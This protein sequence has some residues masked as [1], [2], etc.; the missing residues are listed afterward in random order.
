MKESYRPRN[1]FHVQLLDRDDLD[2]WT[3]ALNCT[4]EQLHEALQAAGTARA[5]VQR[6]LQAR[7]SSTLEGAM[8]IASRII[9][10]SRT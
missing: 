1:I 9:T 2:Y 6:F 5:S 3:T 8:N 10:R 7:R 4:S